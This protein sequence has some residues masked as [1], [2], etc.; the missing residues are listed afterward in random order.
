ME[1]GADKRPEEFTMKRIEHLIFPSER[2][3]YGARDLTLV[4]CSFDGEEDGESALKESRNVTL[5]DCYM[6]LRYPL[7]HDENVRLE[8][9]EMTDKCRAPVW[10]TKHAVILDSVLHGVKAVR[11]CES[12][13]IERSEIVSPEF[14]W[15]SKDVSVSDGSIEGEYM[16]FQSRD[17][18]LDRI[19]QKGKYSFQYVENAELND[20]VLDTKDAFW[21]TKNVT[22]RNTLIRGEYLGWYSDGLTLIGCKIIGTQPLCYCRNLT[23]IDCTTELADLAF[24][25]SEVQADVRGEVLSVKNPYRGRITADAYGEIILTDDAVYPHECEIRV[26]KD[27]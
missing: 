15:R 11:E 22:V 1:T 16:F 8:R 7:W 14:G 9:C 25:Y 6:N 5:Q 3:L 2:A 4:H 19:R 10:Y 27:S 21:H 17:L 20:C 12:V 26:R 13:R 23:L 24:E 18:R